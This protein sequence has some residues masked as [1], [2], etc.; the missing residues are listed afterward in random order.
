M[1]RIPPSVF[2]LRFA[3]QVTH[4]SRVHNP[5]PLN[6]ATMYKQLDQP[7][8]R[9]FDINST[10]EAIGKIISEED[11]HPVSIKKTSCFIHNG[12]LKH[13]DSSCWNDP[14]IRKAMVLGIGMLMRSGN[15]HPKV[16]INFFSYNQALNFF[17]NPYNDYHSDAYFKTLVV[18]FD[19]NSATE[20]VIAVD[21]KYL[22]PILERNGVASLLFP[23][24]GI[25]YLEFKTQ[26]GSVKSILV[27]DDNC[28]H[29][30]HR[31]SCEFDEFFNDAINR[32]ECKTTVPVLHR[33]VQTGPSI[34][35]SVNTEVS[36]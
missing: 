22:L 17:E 31:G 33:G 4:R 29:Q 9:L 8:E 7:I 19:N 25:D 1:N 32:L 16:E 6:K 26:L 12:L 27:H 2:P 3:R 14:D 20:V 21:N 24:T 11:W 28:I 36:F 10:R 5:F 34:V 30:F 35:M 18:G 13:D 15:F 23:Q